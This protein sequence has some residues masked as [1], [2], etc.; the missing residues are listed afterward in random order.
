MAAIQL[1]LPLSSP[2]Q[3]AA[4]YYF[5]PLKEDTVH[6]ALRTIDNF[7]GGIGSTIRSIISIAG[8]V[9]NTWVYYDQWEDGYEGRVT[10]P[11]QSTTQIW[12][13]LN[14]SNGIPPGFAQDLVT[15]G[16]IVTL[17][18]D[19]PVPR[20]ATNIL[21]DGGDRFAVTR[22]VSMT[23]AMYAPVPGEVLSD[24]KQVL[25]VGHHGF[26]F[27]AP[28]GVNVG[29]NQM[30]EYST[31]SVMASFNSTVLDVD[32]NNDGLFE[33]TIYLNMGEH[34]E[35]TNVYAGATLRASKPVQAHLLTGDRG[36]Y[37][38]M[39][40]FT[41][42]PEQMWDS[43][44]YSPVCSS[45]NRYWAEI[46]L[47]NPNTNSVDIVCESQRST[48]TVTVAANGV[49]TYVMPTNT[50]ARFFTTNDQY[51]IPTMTMD[52][53]EVAAYN[54][55][56]DWGYGLCS[57]K[58]L[59]A[60]ALAPWA[61]GSGGTP[62]QYNG[63]PIWVAVLTNTTVYVDYDGNPDT[64]PLLDPVGRHYDFSTNLL[65]LA[66]LK[67]YDNSD[68]DQSRMRI[69]TLDGTPL[70]CAW[71]LD[72]DVAG[73]SNPYLD[74][75]TEV[76]PFPTLPSVKNWT[77]SG[78]DDGEFE[79]ANP[80]DEIKFRIHVAN[81]GY[82]AEP[83][84]ILYDS[85][86]SN[87]TYKAN[88]TYMNGVLVPDNGVPPA[89]TPFPL[90]E[91]GLNIGTLA[92]G[93]TCL[94]EYVVTVLDPFPEE[95]GGVINNV[96]V[97]HETH[98]FIPVARYGLSLEK[99]SLPTNAVYPGDTINYTV[100][101]VNTSNVR[102]TG[103]RLSD[104]IPPYTYWVT[105]S[106]T[107]VLSSPS[108]TW[109]VA[110]FFA[111]TNYLGND[112]QRSW[113]TNW[114]ESGETDGPNAGYVRVMADSNAPA[115]AYM[116]RLNYTGRGTIRR[117]NL[118][119]FT[120]ATLSFSYRRDSMELATEY[121]AVSAS[122][123]GTTWVE[124][125]RLAGPAT[126]LTYQ[127]ASYDLRPF[128][129]SNTHIRFLCSGMYIDDF[130]WIDD[131][132]VKANSPATTKGG[133]PP[134]FVDDYT[135]E[136][137]HS[138]T[139][140]F[141][142][143]VLDSVQGTQIVN[144]A[145]VRSF[146]S[147]EPRSAYATNVLVRSSL[148]GQVRHDVDGDGEVVDAD[149][150]INGVTVQ[151]YTDPN[152][153]GDPADGVLKETAV[154]AGDGYFLFPGYFAGTYTIVET[155][156]ANS[157]STADSSPP[158]DNRI[159]VTLVEGV[160]SLTNLF[161][162]SRVAAIRGQVRADA[163][164]DGDFNDADAGIAGVT[165]Q[166][167]T[168]P[169]GDGDP[170]DGSLLRSTSTDTSGSYEFLRV[171]TGSYVI[172]ETDLIGFYSTADTQGANDNRIAVTL[173]GATDRNGN[174]FLDA[175]S[176]LGITKTAS[177][178][179]IWGPDLIVTYTIHIV[180]TGR[181]HQASVS[182]EDILQEELEYVPDSTEVEYIGMQTNYLLD[183][184]STRSYSNND[185]N[186]SWL[187]GWWE[188]DYTGGTQSPTNGY[189][190]ITN[191]M[192][193][194]QGYSANAAYRRANLAGCEQAYLYF[195]YT[196]VA[197]AAT[198]RATI[199]VSTNNGST[200]IT[201]GGIT[202]QVW[203]VTNYNLTP[204][205][206]TNTYLRFY[207][208]SYYS[209]SYNR[210]FQ[211]DDV[212]IDLI[213][214]VVSY[215]AGGA[216]P[217]LAGG[218]GL[219]TGEY[220]TVTFDAVVGQADA[221]TNTAC[222]YTDLEPEGLCATHVNPVETSAVPWRIAG[223]VRNDLDN[224]GNLNDPDAGIPDVMLTVYTDPNG[225]G[226]PSDGAPITTRY[227][228]HRGYYLFGGLYAGHYAV[229]ETDPSGFASTADIQGA[230]DN[231]I[232]VHLDGSSDSYN[233]D[234]LDVAISGLE[235]QKRCS[236]DGS[237]GAGEVATYT[238]IVTNTRNAAQGGVTVSDYLPAGLTYI[239]D[240]VQVTSRRPVT[241][242]Y[243]RE[244]FT[245]AAYTNQHGAIPW[246]SDWMETNDDNNPAAGFIRIVT[247]PRYLYMYHTNRW[248]ER[249]ADLSEYTNALLSFSYRLAFSTTYRADS[250]HVDVYGGTNA[251]WTPL[252]TYT[253][254]NM[255]VYALTNFNITPW[256]SSD[257]RVRFRMGVTNKY[258][259]QYAYVSN[260][261]IDVQGGGIQTFAGEPPPTLLQDYIIK[262]FEA[263][264]VR[265]NVSAGLFDEDVVNTARVTTAGDPGGR[266]ARAASAVHMIAMTQGVA[267]LMGT[268]KASLLGWKAGTPPI[269]KEYDLL[270]ADSNPWHPGFDL[271]LTDQWQCG[272]T[273]ID[274]HARDTGGLNHCAP[275][276]LGG[277]LRFY[278][279]ARKNMWKTDRDVRLASKEVYVA[280]TLQL[281]EGENWVSLFMEP[282]V[283]T[284]A[285][286]FG[287]NQLPA[288]P[289]MIQSTRV[290]WYGPTQ[291]GASTNTLWLDSLSRTWRRATGGN[292]DLDRLPLHEGFNII[293]P[294]GSGT[295]RL[296]VVGKVPT[297]S[298]AEAGH[299][300]TL[301]P[302]GIYNVVSY[303]FP[304]RITLTNSGLRE[305]GFRGAPA[306]HEVNPNNSDE[307][308]ILRRGGGSMES[309]KVRILMNAQQQFVYWSGGP[310][311]EPAENYRFEVDDA[312][313]YYSRANSNALSWQPE[314]PYAPPSRNIN[315]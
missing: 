76:L 175:S 10:Q 295:Q 272:Q 18:T 241:G 311:L 302:S 86:A 84:V 216:P 131:V 139:A 15:E 218:Y 253:A 153:D 56:H 274:D 136:P 91:D 239:E 209:Y 77:I 9:S 85:G 16:T 125:T 72:P 247:S 221:V 26:L 103:I 174:H 88:S 180:N 4:Q 283:N 97:Q 204:Y 236:D 240:S 107:L 105:N 29:T 194:L 281:E 210:W 80:G 55:N 2:G 65:R 48:S 143:R 191:E 202:G 102:Q 263:L 164:N 300:H 68:K 69:Y 225:D 217:D 112:G 169:D 195:S 196:N 57:D 124:L 81:E 285:G 256:I 255:S 245:T 211:A 58:M 197:A 258:L 284:V 270:W 120:N 252:A 100:T 303:N 92:V 315:P 267:C 49:N 28:V 206:S 278:R 214:P 261:T 104:P 61:P 254:V 200:W 235:I 144:Q 161:L 232:A 289:S 223:Q 66:R 106:T 299:L 78:Y 5:V 152:G 3:A 70:A 188:T 251:E 24:A 212:R 293:I 171:V 36:S 94:V 46:W 90:D 205:R 6:L 166:L 228:N 113:L 155:D 73:T 292:A 183:T 74:M 75:G 39:R 23:R 237:F 96:V 111:A 231:R 264:E 119:P 314:L 296:L 208:A 222:V 219:R 126:D 149:D 12:G 282:D 115:Q 33:D 269:T 11:T 21:Y 146:Q 259:Y 288:G 308:R 37:Y 44:Y 229:V 19:I 294:K 47:F 310:F 266:Y 54:E 34:R 291:S 32:A 313:I 63:S 227:T 35:V 201:I 71:G 224:D 79:A 127:A 312:I 192:L 134:I 64:G 287:T 147:A 162:D 179:G 226:D 273:V 199:Q 276:E 249:S 142:V 186:A 158:N 82:N 67:I 27:R 242:S 118:A 117:L 45:D 170:A 163:D 62:I 151:L 99:S 30:F 176:G 307:L 129:S 160:D 123:N 140:T 114:T 271:S 14:P 193:S 83:D 260:V 1:L 187:T 138:L 41:L 189:I 215:T 98:V 51:F 178:L 167:F 185:G 290:E 20:V 301:I 95:E 135:L 248:I 177:P 257:T 246:S 89:L 198:D 93:A 8:G 157:F 275:E 110:D 137:G 181:I 230:N 121:V 17:L 286:V 243:L 238:I 168:D 150:G 156:L 280:K 40:W 43:S 109:N 53:R 250:W 165:I 213:S 184:F 297:N 133:P 108:N 128:I 52:S 145:T 50:A 87:A 159:P 207:V 7:G 116:L 42:Y 265:L 154:T 31:L 244:L 13:D 173:P 309:P 268:C 234:F 203:G 22:P 298:S 122:S 306:G 148:G 132:E 38:E 190:R 182:V 141:S 279:A 130:V 304:Y 233:N 262:P 277:S 25:H 101:L 220:I 60:M 172:V 59:T 305:A